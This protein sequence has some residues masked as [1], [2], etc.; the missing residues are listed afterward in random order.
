MSKK[1]SPPKAFVRNEFGLI[2]NEDVQY[3]FN[4]S[5]MIDWR[6]MVKPEFLVANR[7]NFEKKNKPVPTSIEGLEDRDLLILLGGIK[8]LAQIRGFTSVKYDVVSPSPE[9]V[10]AT[11]SIVWAPNYETENKEVVFSAI[12]DASTS[13]TSNFARHY[14]GPIAE[15]RAFVRC[16]RNFLKI[17]IVSQEEVGSVKIEEPSTPSNEF[18]PKSLL[19]N[20]MKDKGISFDVLKAKLIKEK[21]EGAEN[22]QS[23]QD[24]PNVKIFELIVR[25]KAAKK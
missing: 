16:V 22:F 2:E 9:Y 11:C 24:I 13:N 14:L 20:I 1:V 25:L 15:N 10:V 6:K 5:G 17:N 4:E 18:N 19:E 8:E 7:Q 3:I 23:T 21:C 12:G